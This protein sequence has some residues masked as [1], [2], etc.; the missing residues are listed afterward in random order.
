MQAST[1]YMEK[2]QLANHSKQALV[3]HTDGVA[4]SVHYR[5][6]ITIGLSSTVYGS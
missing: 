4:D 2:G 3:Q 1:Q 6:S 5:K